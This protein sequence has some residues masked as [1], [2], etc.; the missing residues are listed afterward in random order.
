MKMLEGRSTNSVLTTRAD[1]I[2]RPSFHPDDKPRSKP[3]WRIIS[4]DAHRD[5]NGEYRIR[6]SNG[7]W[8]WVLARGR[9]LRDEMGKP[10][11]FVGSAIDISAQK[12]AQLEKEHLEAQLPPVPENGG[13][14]T[15]AGGIAH[16]FNNILGAILGYGSSLTSIPPKTAP[17]GAT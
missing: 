11:R 7:A 3:Q 1:W 14:R 8:C 12:Q 13:D 2:A 15:L 6:Q 4:R 10:Y 5:M 17:S 9:C 16:D